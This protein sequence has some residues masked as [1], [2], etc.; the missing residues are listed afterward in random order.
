MSFE[1]VVGNTSG[2]CEGV[3]YTVKKAYETIENN[4][5]VFCL[6]EIVHNESVVDD[7]TSKGIKFVNDLN[8]VPAGSMLI[9]RA[10]GAT[11][12]TYNKAK[13]NNIEIVD[14]T[15]GKIRVIRNKIE[16]H[17]DNSFIVIIGKKNHPE[18]EGTLSFCED[19]MIVEREE[20]FDLLKERMSKSNKQSVYIVSQTTFNEEKFNDLCKELSKLFSQYEIVVENTICN[21]T[22]KRQE[23][24][25]ELYN[26]AKENCDKVILIQE[27]NDLNAYENLFVGVNRIG[28]M[29]G[30]S[31]PDQIVDE[32]KDYFEN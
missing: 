13:N 14:L 29:A 17:N 7:L 9:I 6:G 8:E 27:K 23:E 5:N 2:F 30:A 26:V 10:H 21:A 28:I 1:I 32:V 12:E 24:T 25:K 4:E 15:C 20:D 22:H 3:S 31:T 11:K 18:T 16:S 19:G